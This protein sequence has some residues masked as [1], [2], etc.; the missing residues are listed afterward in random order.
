MPFRG[1]D[2][3]V[4]RGG[5]SLESPAYVWPAVLFLGAGFALANGMGYGSGNLRQYLLHALHAL[6]PTY[7]AND[8]FTTQTRAHHTVFNALVVLVGRVA[9]LDV[10]FAVANAFFAA[11]FVIC[12]HLLAARLYRAPILVTAIVAL[13]WVVGPTTLIGMTAILSPYF[14]PSTIGAVGLLM[15]LT[16]LIYA[17]HRLAGLVL[18][19]AALCHVNYMVWIAVIAAVVVAANFRAIGRRQAAFLLIPIAIAAA[20][21]LPFLLEGRSPEQAAHSAAAGRILHDIYMPYHS[22]PLTWGI[23]PFVRFAAFLAAGGISLIVVG[24]QRPPGRVAVS[25]LATIAGIVAIGL[26]LTTAVQVDLIALLFPYRLAPFLVLASII[27]AAGAMVTTAHQ[28]SLPAGRTI[29]LWIVLGTLLHCA[30]VSRYALLCAGSA[31]VALFAGRLARDTSCSTAKMV[32]LPTALAA[33][34]YLGGAGK[35]GTAFVAAA[36]IGA[37]C[38]KIWNRRRGKAQTHRLNDNGTVGPDGMLLQ[39][40]AS[41]AT[42]ANPAERASRR[43]SRIGV[44]ANVLLFAGPVVPLLAAAL[45][46]QV[47][48]TRK[49]LTGPPPAA[50]ELA[51]YDWCRAK[52]DRADV[53]I[54]P[55]L[56]EEFRLQAQRA[57][58]IDWKCM[59]ILPK[60]TV[61]WYRRLVDECGTEFDS[62][63]QAQA[64]YC[65]MDAERA[66]RLASRY[67]AQYVIIEQACHTGDLSGLSCL[68]HNSAYAVYDLQ[69]GTPASI[70]TRPTAPA[71]ADVVRGGVT[72]H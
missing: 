19:A 62:L 30:G 47:G 65:G 51:L 31:T 53:F 32:V 5:V 68:Y 7:L 34:L 20:F 61:E 8:W 57:V 54:I 37:V 24:V 44:T 42:P 33:G 6:D 35:A 12:T 60:D 58:V 3:S 45:L 21:H 1:G 10:S 46:M 50:D 67:R 69:G 41:S 13:C 11:A 27:A 59:P 14:Q 25:I 52:T 71:V 18:G 64:G 70:A 36:V 48:S 9:R 40:T 72:S 4:K 55:P 56:L 26:V 28:Q 39:S 66:G 38:W 63:H 49:D 23:E 15:G 43:R 22:R 16:C 29:V 17:R 2:A